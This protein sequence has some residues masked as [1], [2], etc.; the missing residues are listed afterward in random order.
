MMN[1]YIRKHMQWL[2]SPLTPTE[3]KELVTL[4]LMALDF[5]VNPSRFVTIEAKQ[6]GIETFWRT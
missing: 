1:E 2:K 5:E 3:Q 4:H 6:L